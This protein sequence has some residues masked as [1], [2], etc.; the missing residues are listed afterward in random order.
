M[1]VQVPGST[2]EKDTNQDENFSAGREG[3]DSEPEVSSQWKE[4]VDS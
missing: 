2:L 4:R 1:C 3:R